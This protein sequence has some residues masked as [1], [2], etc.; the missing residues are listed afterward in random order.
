M[1]QSHVDIDRYLQ[2]F[3]D[4]YRILCMNLFDL[5]GQLQDLSH[6]WSDFVWKAKYEIIKIPCLCFLLTGKFCEQIRRYL[7]FGREPNTN[8]FIE[9]LS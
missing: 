8:Y 9:F 4:R 1:C 5:Q 2:N 7:L 3:N 6:F